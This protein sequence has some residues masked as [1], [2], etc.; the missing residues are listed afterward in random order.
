MTK[1]KRIILERARQLRKQMTPAERALWK[2]LRA[3]RLSKIK[4]YNQ[5]PIGRFIADFYCARARLVIEVDGSIHDL[6]K[7]RDQARDEWLMHY[8]VLTVRFSN[9]EVLHQPDSVIGSLLTIIAQRSM[10]S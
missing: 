2:L 1:P 5:R 4:F 9:E 7:E 3:K 6:Q 8:G 10:P